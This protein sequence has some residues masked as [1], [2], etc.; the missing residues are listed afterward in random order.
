MSPITLEPIT[1]VPIQIIESPPT[2]HLDIYQNLEVYGYYAGRGGENLYANWQHSTLN[3]ESIPWQPHSTLNPESLPWQPKDDVCRGVMVTEPDALVPVIGYY[4]VNKNGTVLGIIARITTKYCFIC[5]ESKGLS[6]KC[7][8]FGKTWYQV[9]ELKKG[10]QSSKFRYRMSKKSQEVS[11]TAKC[12]GRI[13]KNSRT[14][15]RQNYFPGRY[16]EDLE[17]KTLG[18]V[19]CTNKSYVFDEFLLSTNKI[20]LNK[21]YLTTWKW[22]T[23]FAS[24]FDISTLKQYNTKSFYDD[25]TGEMMLMGS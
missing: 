22:S 25:E 20:I 23:T 13:T 5:N 4:A 8:N 3:P 17:G 15:K 1:L 19:V 6:I 2:Q 11:T 21:D 12:P 10:R 24:Q 18:F 14:V 7:D 16:V 9:K